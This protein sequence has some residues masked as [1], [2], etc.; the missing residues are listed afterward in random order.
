MFTK[1]LPRALT[2]F[3]L[4]LYLNAGNLPLYLRYDS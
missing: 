2:F 1:E 3:G 4:V